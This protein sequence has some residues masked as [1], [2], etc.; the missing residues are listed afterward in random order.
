MFN[1]NTLEIADGVEDV[2]LHRPGSD[3]YDGIT[4]ALARRTKEQD[5]RR[6]NRLIPYHWTTWHLPQAEVNTGDEILDAKAN[7]WIVTKI[8]YTE[9]TGTVRCVSYRFDAT[10]GLD[11]YVDLFRKR[12]EPAKSGTLEYRWFLV[13]S[14][15][16][17]K[18]SE[19]IISDGVESRRIAVRTPVDFRTGDQL[20]FPDGAYWRIE[21]V[22]TPYDNRF[23]TELKVVN[24]VGSRQTADGR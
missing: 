5:K 3:R 9:L 24:E 4:G 13:R 19:T 7:R 8:E 15:I 17:A 1:D 21:G 18:F 16:P 14:G 2:V 23:W 12:G 20:R 11:E 10:F 6:E 22:M